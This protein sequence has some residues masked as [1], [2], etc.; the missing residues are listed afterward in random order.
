MFVF[1][2]IN[3]ALGAVAGSVVTVLVPKVFTTV[4]TEV[5][6]V[7][8]KASTEAKTVVADVKSKV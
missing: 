7:E 6:V 2:L 4:K 5:A 1:D 8:A 3:F